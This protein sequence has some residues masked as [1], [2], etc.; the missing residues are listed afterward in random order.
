MS[1]QH[2]VLIQNI[3]YA[4]TNFV[5]M[6]NTFLMGTHIFYTCNMVVYVSSY[7]ALFNM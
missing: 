1:T 4:Y 2:F 7:K 6:Y 3:S 5:Y